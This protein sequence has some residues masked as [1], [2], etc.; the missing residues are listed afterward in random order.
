MYE[1]GRF[2]D[3]DPSSVE[4]RED[5]I[6]VIGAMTAD[7]H[8]HPEA[9]ENPTLERF[10][11]ALGALLESRWLQAEEPSWRLVAEAL[12]SASGYE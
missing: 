11:E 7:L 1:T 10:L 3:V 6:A 2:A 12:V 8:L 4:T 9:W 5:T